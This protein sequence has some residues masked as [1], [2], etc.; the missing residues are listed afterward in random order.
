MMN[1]NAQKGIMEII[2]ITEIKYI[3]SK[4]NKPII[5]QVLDSEGKKYSV[6]LMQEAAPEL[7]TDYAY[8]LGIKDY[9]PIQKQSIES[10]NNKDLTLMIEKFLSRGYDEAMIL[11][12]S[13]VYFDNGV[14]STVYIAMLKSTDKIQ[15]YQ[16]NVVTQIPNLSLNEKE[17][18]Q[19]I[20]KIVGN[21]AIN[22]M[23]EEGSN[24]CLNKDINIIQDFFP[25]DYNI[26]SSTEVG[27]ILLGMAPYGPEEVRNL[28]NSKDNI[29]TT[30]QLVGLRFKVAYHESNRLIKNYYESEFG[31]EKKEP[32]NL[33]Q[34][35]WKMQINKEQLDNSLSKVLVTDKVKGKILKALL[36]EQYNQNEQPKHNINVQKDEEEKDPDISKSILQ[37]MGEQD[38]Q[39]VEQNQPLLDNDELEVEEEAQFEEKNKPEQKI[40]DAMKFQKISEIAK[41]GAY[42]AEN[43]K[44]LVKSVNIL[45][46]WITKANSDLVAEDGLV[47]VLSTTVHG[48]FSALNAYSNNGVSPIVN[49]LLFNIKEHTNLLNSDNPAVQC[50]IDIGRSIISG[51]ATFNIYSAAI[52]AVTTGVKCGIQY[53]APENKYSSVL[54]SSFDAISTAANYMSASN[55]LIKGLELLKF[56]HAINTQYNGMS[57][58]DHIAD[59]L[60]NIK[61]YSAYNAYSA[62]YNMHYNNENITE[63]NTTDINNDIKADL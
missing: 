50:G 46:K 9:Q 60:N 54:L 49:T 8:N 23:Q 4:D 20:G 57:T 16:V 39:Q 24:V 38:E 29:M 42:F 35:I 48:L 37:K 3:N 25:N 53:Y 14:S 43:Y 19:T 10:D 22:K 32:E 40:T 63:L 2:E 55:I 13:K 36:N 45:N 1:F 21:Q 52:N 51:L 56:A 44:V 18:L 59:L 7:L 61:D 6:S 34:D 47:K 28:L 33:L 11:P 26:N 30:D 62:Y 58:L 41:T 12:V 15:E 5:A 31:F 27:M 17:N